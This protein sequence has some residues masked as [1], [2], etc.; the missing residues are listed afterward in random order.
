MHTL[1]IYYA[2][3]VKS[4]AW[5]KTKAAGLTCAP[6]SPSSPYYDMPKVKQRLMPSPEELEVIESKVSRL[7]QNEGWGRMEAIKP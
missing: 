5:H 7:G 4:E 3:V 6:A 1:C 2:G